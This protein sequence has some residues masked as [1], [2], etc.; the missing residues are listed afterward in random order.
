M[1]ASLRARGRVARPELTRLKSVLAVCAHPDDESFGLG[2]VVAWLADA[3]TDVGLICLTHG[4]A[5]TLGVHANLRELRGDELKRAGQ[6]LGLT[7]TRL[8]DYADGRLARTPQQDLIRDVA[9][10]IEVTD[11]DAVLVFDPEGVTGHEDHRTA[12]AIGR[13]AA[14]AASI[15]VLAWVIPAE[16][17]EALNRRFGTNFN[18]YSIEAID[19]V[20]NVD[21]ARQLR[22]VK[23]HNS[24]SVENPVLRHRLELMGNT[25]WLMYLGDSGSRDAQQQTLDRPNAVGEES[26]A[27]ANK[28]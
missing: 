10:A 9:D 12:T 7:S 5:S 16:V 15:P 19:C 24:Q 13:A 17:A 8:F 2:A 28:P 27:D 18:G 6:V 21:R 20:L 3:G 1:N 14:A 11:A 26:P 22:A 25:E 4:E 23:E